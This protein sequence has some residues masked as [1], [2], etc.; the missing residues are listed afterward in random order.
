[1]LSYWPSQEIV[2]G[3]LLNCNLKRNI[4]FFSPPTHVKRDQFTVCGQKYENVDE[5]ILQRSVTIIQWDFELRP[6]NRGQTSFFGVHVYTFTG[7]LAQ[8]EFNKVKVHHG[9]LWLMRTRTVHHT[10]CLWLRS[11]LTCMIL[12][13]Y[14][15]TLICFNQPRGIKPR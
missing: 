11:W 8:R 14:I 9:W 7:A 10:V 4:T 15:V 2:I 3:R 5:E 6:L 1:M 13:I 12:P